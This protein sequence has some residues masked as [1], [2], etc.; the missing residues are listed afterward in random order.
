MTTV[1]RIYKALAALM[2]A[3]PAP[4][5]ADPFT[6]DLDPRDAETAWY[7]DPPSTVSDG[8]VGGVESVRATFAIWLSRPAAD[9]AAGAAVALAGDVARLRHAVAALDVDPTGNVNVQPT[10]RTEIRP[11][12]SGAVTVVGRLVVSFDYEADAENP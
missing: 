2:A 10:I 5:S 7:I 6:F 11:R 1:E 3:Q 8:A 9:D 12:A 4:P